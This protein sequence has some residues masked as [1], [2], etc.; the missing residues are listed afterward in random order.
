LD[1]LFEIAITEN[2]RGIDKIIVAIVVAQIALHQ[3]ER[4]SEVLEW[5]VKVFENIISN[6]DNNNLFDTSFLNFLIVDIIAFRGTEL[7]PFIEK[8]NKN[9]WL[10]EQ[11]QGD[12]EAI[13]IS[14]SKE[15]CA[16]EIK[17]LPIDIHEYYT[18]EYLDRQVRRKPT[19]ETL[20]IFERMNSRAEL[21][22]SSMWTKTLNKADELEDYD[23]ETTGTIRNEQPKTGR[24][25]PCPCGS[26]K[27]YKKCCLRK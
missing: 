20:D 2:I 16:S 9:D 17:P 21:Y 26:G 11:F 22:V 1:E 4:R 12:I 23:Y 5:Y 13:K 15:P 18:K 14:I 10:D 24:N 25:E 3:P 27:K 8:I 19:Q 7:L 6:A